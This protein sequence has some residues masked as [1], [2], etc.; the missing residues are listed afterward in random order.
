MELDQA[1]SVLIAQRRFTVDEAS[2]ELLDAP[3][4]HRIPPPVFA[5][6]PIALAEGGTS[7][8][9]PAIA[10]ARYDRGLLLKTEVVA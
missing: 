5:R 3:K 10:A 9:E 1:A 6:A 7:D 4:R 8:D 2:D